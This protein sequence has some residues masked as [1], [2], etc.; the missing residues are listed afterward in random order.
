MY[1]I[2]RWLYRQ[3]GFSR[4]QSN[5]FLLLLPLTITFIFSAPLYRACQKNTCMDHQIDD[6]R[7]LDSL[8]ALFRSPPAQVAD[9]LFPFDPNRVTVDDMKRLGIPA[10]LSVRIERF[11]MSGGSFRK[12][13]DL[14]RIYGMDSALYL[15]LEPFIDLPERREDVKKTARVAKAPETIRQISRFDLNLADT[16]TLKAVRGIGDKLSVRI[17]RYRDA[18]GGY[19]GL[20][21]LAEVYAM[22]SFRIAELQRHCFID[23]AFQPRKININKAARQDIAGHP[24]ISPRQAGSIVAYRFNHGNFA[25][26]EDLVRVGNLDSVTFRKIRPYLTVE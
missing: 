4:A 1:F 20:Q 9:T 26:I 2:Y 12:E 10:A 23:P 18:L 11:R 19:V 7:R 8:A 15:R 22:D 25:S 24:Y 5:G 16:V 21:Q 13:H 6:M 17:I 3:V 14:L